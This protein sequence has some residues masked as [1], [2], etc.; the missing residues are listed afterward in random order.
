M[1]EPERAD[2]EQRQSLKEALESVAIIQRHVEIIFS[3]WGMSAMILSL[4][5]GS[6][7]TLR[8]GC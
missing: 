8:C 1:S 5:A 4:S 2:D 3:E 6:L 7:F